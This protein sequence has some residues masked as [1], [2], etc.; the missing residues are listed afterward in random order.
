MSPK[1]WTEEARA[2][3]RRIVPASLRRRYR[4]TRFH[5][6]RLLGIRQQIQG[7][8]FRFEPGTEPSYLRLLDNP[9]QALNVAQLESFR[10]AIS[11]GAVVFDVGASVGLYSLVAAR[12]TG[13]TGTVVAFE[14]VPAAAQLL[15]SNLRRN[16]V[17]RIV[18]VCNMAVGSGPGTLSLYV[19]GASS[20]NTA[21]APDPH[22]RAGRPFTT[23]EVPMVSLDGEVR[24]CGLQPDIVKIDVEG[25]ELQVLQGMRGLLG[26]TSKV[27]CEMHPALWRDRL[28]T[29]AAILQ[30]AHETGRALVDLRN[31]PRKSLD[32]GPYWLAASP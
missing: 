12:A 10:K 11:R 27:L 6:D 16:H 8:W 30:I 2:A 28:S 25:W 20:E 5:L 14:P 7:Y 32:Y 4:A 18:Q 15:R 26:G 3:V 19:S 9:V 24:R 31:E 13:P 22:V 21:A 23:I 1:I 17:E 29:E